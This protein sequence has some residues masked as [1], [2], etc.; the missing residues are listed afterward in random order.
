MFINNTDSHW[1]IV[2]LFFTDANGAKAFAKHN[3]KLNMPVT[4]SS[5]GKKCIEEPR[6]KQTLTHRNN[7]QPYPSSYK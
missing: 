4:T 5:F 1:Y 7:Q 2:L 6:S 3:C